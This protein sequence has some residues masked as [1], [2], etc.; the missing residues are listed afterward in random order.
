MARTGTLPALTK[1]G[2]IILK[3]PGE[4]SE[5]PDGNG[6]IYAALAQK[7]LPSGISVLEDLAAH[8]IKYIHAYCVDNCLV[9][10]ADPTFIGYCISENAECAA[11]LR[12]TT[13]D[14][15]RCVVVI[16]NCQGRLVSD[17]DPRCT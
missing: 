2:K 9:R 4:V 14:G 7:Q 1:D 8:Q 17:A 5:A 6:G 13:W 11:M 12:L 3:G 10:V 16:V 15:V